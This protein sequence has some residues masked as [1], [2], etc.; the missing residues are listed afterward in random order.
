MKCMKFSIRGHS[1]SLSVCNFLLPVVETNGND[2]YWDKCWGF[3]YEHLMVES[4]RMLF[5]H[6]LGCFIT[7]TCRQAY[8][9]WPETFSHMLL[10]VSV[11]NHHLFCVPG[12]RIITLCGCVKCFSQLEGGAFSCVSDSDWP[13]LSLGHGA[14]IYEWLVPHF[15]TRAHR[16]PVTRLWCDSRLR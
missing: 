4:G 5:L 9:V 14:Q 8:K 11:S 1:N 13:F 6:A 15:P 7:R 2:I 10:P 16:G 12:H 3:T